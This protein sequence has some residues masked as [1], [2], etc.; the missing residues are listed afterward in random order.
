M[1]SRPRVDASLALIEPYHHPIE[2]RG[3]QPLTHFFFLNNPAPPEPSP[4]PPHAALPISQ[5]PPRPPPAQARATSYP[6]Q[7]G[8]FVPK[9]CASPCWRQPMSR[10]I[11]W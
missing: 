10:F 6:P 1:I 9:G 4:L 8:V 2:L 7:S 5:G 3:Q 11:A